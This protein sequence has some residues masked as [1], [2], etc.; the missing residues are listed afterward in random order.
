M[1]VVAAA[2]VVAALLAVPST[3]GA[4]APLPVGEDDGVRIV[5]ERGAIVVVFTSS[6]KKLWR[7]VAGRRVRVYCTEFLDGGTAEGG[8]THRAPKRGRRIRTGDLTRGI[9]YCDVSLETRSGREADRSHPVDTAR[10]GIRR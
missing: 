7:R 5:R 3:A 2:L 10:R 1:R 4:Q 6:A 9:D 8:L